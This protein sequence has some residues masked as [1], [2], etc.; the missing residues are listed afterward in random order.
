MMK[1]GTTNLFIIQHGLKPIS[2]EVVHSFIE[3]SY[4]RAKIYFHDYIKDKENKISYT[5]YKIA[6]IDRELK[7]KEMKVFIATGYE[8]KFEKSFQRSL[9]EEKKRIEEASKKKTIA[10]TL[11]ILFEGKRC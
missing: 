10:Q 7:V 8:I 6:E 3:Q 2:K 1:H 11:E 4:E 9:L 5:L